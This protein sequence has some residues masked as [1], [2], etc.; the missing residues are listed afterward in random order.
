MPSRFAPPSGPQVLYKGGMEFE[1]LVTVRRSIRR[2]QSRPVED[3]TLSRL[4]H[5]ALTAPSAGNT[6]PYEIVVVRREETRAA[7]AHAA[8]GQR[9]LAQAPVILVFLHDVPRSAA[10]YGSRGA[11]L[12]VVQDTAIACAYAQL[13]ATALGLGA[14]WVGAFH[15]EAVARAIQ[16]PAHLEPAVLLA[17]GYPDERPRPPGRRPFAEV[18]KQESA[19][20][21]TPRR[22]L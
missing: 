19:H 2:F 10:A 3:E 18:V 11:D 22:A 5:A 14:C 21:P 9:F 1:E 6:Q 20:P 7:L 4:L 13:A 15:P 16:A 12:Y 17:L 8:L